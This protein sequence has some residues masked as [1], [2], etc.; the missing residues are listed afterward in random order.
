MR[1][2]Y[3][4]H[5]SF[6]TASCSRYLPDPSE[7]RDTLQDAFVIIFSSLDRFE[8]RG[9]GSLR[10]WMRQ[11]VV[12]EALKRLRGRRRRPFIPLPEQLP[13]QAGEEDPEVS[14]VPA[15]VLQGMIR[16]LPEG[17]RTVLNLYAFE[18]KSHREIARLLGISENTSASQLHRARAFLSREITQYRKKQT[19]I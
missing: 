18:N 1:R 6:L 15:S 4:C 19:Q 10:A 12:N 7:M 16:R 14:Q 17:Y 5:A 3:D 13:E 8:F 9:E 11:I 2:I